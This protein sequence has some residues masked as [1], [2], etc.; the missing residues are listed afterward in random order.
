EI[1]MKHL[2]ELP[3]LTG[4]PETY[5]GVLR[6]ALEKDPL[7]RTSSAGQLLKEFDAAVA[8]QSA[9]VSAPVSAEKL[10]Y[11]PGRAES[12]SYKAEQEKLRDE[13]RRATQPHPQHSA[14]RSRSDAASAERPFQTWFHEN[15][16][17]VVPIAVVALWFTP[18]FLGGP[19][20]LI[21]GVFNLAVLVGL[22]LVGYR[23]FA[24]IKE[25]EAKRIKRQAEYQAGGGRRDKDIPASPIF[26]DDQRS[27]KP[28][29]PQRRSH[30]A[31]HFLLPDTVREIPLKVR[32]A[33]LLTSVG[34]ASLFSGL[35]ATVLYLLTDSI[36]TIPQAITFG[37]C[38]LIPSWAILAEC[39]FLEGRKVDG[40]SR[41]VRM[42]I[43][44]GVVGMV[45]AQINSYL[46][47]PLNFSAGAKH[48][49][50]QLGEIGSVNF[51]LNSQ[52]LWGVSG[53]SPFIFAA[54]FGLM[55]A[56]RQW[57]WQVDSFRPARLRVM[58]IL[59]TVLVA[60]FLPWLVGFPFELGIL[61]AAS[62]SAVVQLSA[63]WTPR[64]ERRAIV[65]QS[66]TQPNTHANRS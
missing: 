18:R 3:D 13:A 39:K 54:F 62:L 46:F 32:M 51:G 26:D 50:E 36:A 63:C 31:S 47:D 58:S 42:L 20:G 11:S 64:E 34:L 19:L 55:F 2:T 15:W 59:V 9:Y 1:L 43:V 35:V 57:W 49:L 27:R 6:R 25:E 61:W 53:T 14:P 28:T 56:L 41:R 29:S 40:T 65:A 5:R 24:Y 21:G 22:V 60:F 38:L 23:V 12:P 48:Q 45:V 4:V 44:G 66:V 16:V 10:H 30:V 17:Y 52:N 37:T 8:G 7:K 33:E